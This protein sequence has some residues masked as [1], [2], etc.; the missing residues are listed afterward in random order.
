MSLYLGTIGDKAA[1]YEIHAFTNGMPFR[2]IPTSQIAD[3]KLYSGMLQ[4]RYNCLQQ[5]RAIYCTAVNPDSVKGIEINPHDDREDTVHVA[6]I[7]KRTQRISCMLSIAVDT[8]ETSGSSVIGLPL[9]NRWQQNGYPEGSSLDKFREKYFIANQRHDQ[10]IKPAQMAELYRHI[11]INGESDT[12][13]ARLGIYV[14]LYHLLVREPR[15]RSLTETNVWVFDAI[16]EYFHLYRLAG[17]AVLRDLT[18]K[19]SPRHISPGVEEIKIGEYKGDKCWFYKNDIVSRTVTVPIPQNTSGKLEFKMTDVPFLDG[20]ID[21][22]IIEE[23]LRNDP[24]GMSLLKYEGMSDRDM[25]L[26]CIA[27]S[28]FGKRHYEQVYGTNN[29]VKYHA[30]RNRE[31]ISPIWDFNHVGE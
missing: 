7:D 27:V 5:G 4:E 21:I 1:Q 6:S 23:A 12:L 3:A 14:G 24:F 2:F 15:N 9:E 29:D 8:G 11:K 20:V 19:D 25:Q 31:L 28:C 16:P 10:P 26:L 18:I 13:M 22:Q 17:A 30:D